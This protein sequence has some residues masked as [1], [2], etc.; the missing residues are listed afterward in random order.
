MNLTRAVG[1]DQRVNLPRSYDDSQ[2]LTWYL[3]CAHRC[4]ALAH[5]AHLRYHWRQRLVFGISFLLLYLSLRIE[6]RHVCS[7]AAEAQLHS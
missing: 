4:R 6:R 3:L 5:H 1:C 2:D 7:S